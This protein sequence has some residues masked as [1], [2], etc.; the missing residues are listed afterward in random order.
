[1]NIREVE[2]DKIFGILER[3][4]SKHEVKQLRVLDI[5]KMLK[6][7]QGDNN[8]YI[9]DKD[10]YKIHLGFKICNEEEFLL[11][12]VKENGEWRLTDYDNIA[13]NMF[14]VNLRVHIYEEALFL[15]E[16]IFGV[17]YGIKEGE[18][19]YATDI[20][21]DNVLQKIDAMVNVFKMFA[22]LIDVVDNNQ[23]VQNG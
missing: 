7:P 11:W 17:N 9:I 10:S 14:I 18:G 2:M 6:R 5:E 23:E 8:Q 1:M 3:I 16:T 12:L 21:E 13:E 22:G 20:T 4:K 15:A 19:F